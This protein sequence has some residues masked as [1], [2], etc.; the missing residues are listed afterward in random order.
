MAAGGSMPLYSFIFG[1]LIDAYNK[2]EEHMYDEM[3]KVVVYVVFLGIGTGVSYWGRTFFWMFSSERQIK[4]IREHYVNAILRQEVTWFDQVGSGELTTRIAGDTIVV[5]DGMGD[6]VGLFIQCVCM[7]ICG[8]IMGF[9]RGWKMALVILSVVPLIAICGMMMMKLLVSFSTR[10][11]KVYATAGNIAEEVLSSIRT[12]VA[13]GGEEKEVARYAKSLDDAAVIG[14]KKTAIGGIGKGFTFFCIFGTYALALWYGG[15]LVVEDDSYTGGRVINV[16]WSVIFAAFMLGQAGPNMEAIAKARGAAYTIFQTI[17]RTPAIDASS[18]NGERIKDF[19]GN[20]ELKEVHFKYPT[21]QEVD[22]FAGVNITVKAGQ[23]IALVGKSGCGKSS[24]VA[25]LQRFYDAGA[26]EVLLDGK[27]I[28]T[29]NVK[30]LRQ[31]FGYVGQE[32]VLFS[33]TIGDNISFG[34]DVTQEEIENAAR[35]ANAHKFISQFPD[36][37]K[38]HVGERG[39]QL[40]GGQKQRIAIA[41]AILKNPKIL[42]L[43]EATSA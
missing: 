29:L 18:D 27:D 1:E 31:Q 24:V 39:A 35:A 2:G 6:K 13:F 25:L 20:I 21:R 8:M 3:R 12:V 26:G 11:Q 22:V 5:Q 43:D 36:G 19:K 23:K 15:K 9:V 40:S 34:Q 30:W 33:G 28:K 37:Y 7:F 10:G 42:L 41:R 16:L 4:R 38:T 32:P 14:I 17:D